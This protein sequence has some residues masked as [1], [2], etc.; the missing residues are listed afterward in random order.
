MENTKTELLKAAENLLRQNPDPRKITVRQIT[1]RAGLGTG[2]IN[3]HFKNK[4]N[5]IRAAIDNMLETAFQ[6]ISSSVPSQ[7]PVQQLKYLLRSMF[8]FSSE[9]E[10]LIR[11][12]LEQ[13]AADGSRGAELS[14]IPLLR[15][16][17]PDKN[18]TDFR[19]LAMQLISPLQMAGIAPEAFRIY[20]GYDIS[21]PEERQKLV[22]QLIRNLVSSTE[23]DKRS[24]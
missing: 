5:L 11:F 16:I 1:E 7:S 22:E 19:I 10:K 15:Q 3:Y 2:L 6:D 4:D 18:E 17:W 24:L 13:E 8:D 9:Y 21:K 20:S 23:S 12:S 14:L